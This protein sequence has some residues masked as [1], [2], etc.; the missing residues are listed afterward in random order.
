VSIV[1]FAGNGKTLFY[2]TTFNNNASP[3]KVNQG[4]HFPVIFL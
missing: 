2:L 4:G 3:T 1:M